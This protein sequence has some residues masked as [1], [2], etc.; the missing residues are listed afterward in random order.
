MRLHIL[1]HTRR[2]SLAD[3]IRDHTLPGILRIHIQACKCTL[4]RT[5]AEQNYFNLS[6]LLDCKME[7]HTV[8]TPIKRPIFFLI[9]R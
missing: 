2:R 1:E 4:H 6:F 3:T 5:R 7:K 9:N 8:E